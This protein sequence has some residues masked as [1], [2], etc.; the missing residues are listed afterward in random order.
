ML[1]IFLNRFS[2]RCYFISKAQLTWGAASSDC[3]AKNGKL[4]SA[5]TWNEWNKTIPDPTQNY[6]TGENVKIR[7][8]VT[9][10]MLKLFAMMV[11]KFC[12][13]ITNRSIG[14]VWLYQTR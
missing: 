6:W 3:A 8:V 14:S 11:G 5:K 13:Y 9:S 10:E 12:T 1:K 4:V 2:G 7:N